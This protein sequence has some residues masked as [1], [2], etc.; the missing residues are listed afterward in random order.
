MEQQKEGHQRVQVNI[1]QSGGTR[2]GSLWMECCQ[3]ALRIWIETGLRISSNSANGSACSV[4]VSLLTAR[5]TVPNS[6]LKNH[7]PPE[8][9]PGLDKHFWVLGPVL[10]D[11]RTPSSQAAMLISISSN[12]CKHRSKHFLNLQSWTH[13]VFRYRI[14]SF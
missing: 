7:L 2:R 4:L 5:S 12:Y 3:F 14:S 9:L 11:L 8:F 6:K 13:H 10:E 1:Q